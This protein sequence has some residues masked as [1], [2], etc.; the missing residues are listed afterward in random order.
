[1]IDGELSRRSEM[2]RAFWYLG[3]TTTIPLMAF[4]GYV[5]GRQYNKEVLG[6]L[7]GTLLGTVL[8]WLDML[9]LGGIIGKRKSQSE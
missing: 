1:M 4:A 6:A 8:V 7:A 9:K 3:V 5:I 2:G